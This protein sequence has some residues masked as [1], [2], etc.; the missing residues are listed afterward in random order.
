MASNIMLSSEEIVVCPKCSHKFPIEQGITK[1]TI[2][3][4]E[5]EYDK[6]FQE[7]SNELKEEL[8]KV[9]AKNAEKVYKSKISELTDE[10]E[11]SKEA[12]QESGARMKK[13]RKDAEAKAY[14]EFEQERKSLK[15]ELDD[16]EAAIKDFKDREITLRRE[17]KK[18]E[19]DKRNFELE[20]QRKLD[21]AKKE[22]EKSIREAEA[23]KFNYKEA[24]YKKKL[25]AALKANE[26]LTRKLE[27][28]SQQLQGEVLELELQR[29]LQE[30]FPNDH[31][32]EIAKGARGADVLQSVCT[33]GGHICGTIIW[34]AKRAQNR[35]DKWL[36]KLQDDRMAETADIAVL[37][38][39]TMPKDCS[40]AF[41]IIGNIW[42]VSYRV[43]RPIAETLR[44]MLIETSKLKLANKGRGE[45]ADLI[46]DYLCSPNF[47]N[48]V[49]SVIETFA[50]MKRD[51]DRE[52]NAMYKTWKK[53]ESQ[54]ER[55][56]V[57]MSSMV[58]ELQAIAQESLPQLGKIDQLLLPGESDE[59]QN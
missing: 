48:D 39:T 50:Y 44:V 40:E 12:L 59:E 36:Q 33:Q 28:G 47:G 46:Y 8:S 51:L 38:S 31:I 32:K 20:Q 17:K 55:V 2:E 30:A 54:L 10:L 14:K 25:D 45:K 18:L 6:V 52:K 24:E 35:S 7:R 13:I 3:Q 29:I 5:R 43:I 58:G 37:V 19:E 41:K 57:S 21:D 26:D 49:R 9:A 56:A 23:E 53:R 1:Q 11:S 15:E 22:I 42:V 4:R 16:K 27:Q 34:E